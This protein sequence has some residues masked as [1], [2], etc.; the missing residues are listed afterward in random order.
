VAKKIR[1]A[2]HPSATPS[3]DRC[4][5]VVNA[6]GRVEAREA[7]LLKTFSKPGRASAREEQGRA[8]YSSS[9]AFAELAERNASRNTQTHPA[10]TQH[11][12]PGAN[13]A[14]L[15]SLA[16]T[17]TERGT[18]TDSDKAAGANL[19]REKYDIADRGRRLVFVPTPPLAG[20]RG[21]WPA[22]SL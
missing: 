11:P 22:N 8:N 14:P 16:A 17:L 15:S 1:P 7:A 9:V 12:S 21:P 20:L 3:T 19:E 2:I 13:S 10:L 4:G 18:L 5:Q 6:N